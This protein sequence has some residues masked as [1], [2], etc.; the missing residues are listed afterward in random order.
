MSGLIS[1]PRTFTIRALWLE[2]LR[3]IGSMRKQRI[4]VLTARSSTAFR[5]WARWILTQTLWCAQAPVRSTC[6]NPPNSHSHS[7]FSTKASKCGKPFQAM[8][9]PT[10]LSKSDRQGSS[11][12][13]FPRWKAWRA[14]VRR[15][16]MPR[17]QW[18]DVISAKMTSAW[19]N[20][21]EQIDQKKFHP[22]KE[23]QRLEVPRQIGFSRQITSSRDQ[24]QSSR[25]AV[26]SRTGWRTQPALTTKVSSSTSTSCPKNVFSTYPSRHEE[27]NSR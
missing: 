13:T 27:T 15:C 1:P 6:K 16:R 4:R 18:L 14:M 3:S 26:D 5:R 7:P 24:L 10:H 23:A 12:L 25:L 21:V 19:L 8:K 17:C 9:Q 22:L 11:G 20:S 2:W